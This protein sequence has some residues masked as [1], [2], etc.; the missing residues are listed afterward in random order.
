MKTNQSNSGGLFA[1]HLPGSDTVLGR[2]ALV[3][4]SLWAEEP[5]LA[6]LG[7]ISTSFHL[8]L[9]AAAKARPRQ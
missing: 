6:L 4:I 9:S 2:A 1:L 7:V 5:L 8:L 3:E